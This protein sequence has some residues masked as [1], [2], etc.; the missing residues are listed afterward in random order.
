[1]SEQNFDF[2]A[3]ASLAQSDPEAFEA[4]R[5]HMIEQL[6]E[7]APEGLRQRLRGFQWR[8]DMERQRCGNPLQACIRISNM[9]WDMIYADRGFLWSLQV[10]SDPSAMRTAVPEEQMRA[11]VVALK[12]VR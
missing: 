3:W 12:P 11:E 6:I 10:M 8:I 5:L 7:S 1:M 2:D 4:K 9:M